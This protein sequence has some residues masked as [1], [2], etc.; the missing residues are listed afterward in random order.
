[1]DEKRHEGKKKEVVKVEGHWSDRNL[2]YL[3][4]NYAIHSLSMTGA[5]ALVL[6]NNPRCILLKENVLAGLL[7]GS[8]ICI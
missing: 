2:I 3:T 8:V 5:I 7:V 6:P 1:M 4:P